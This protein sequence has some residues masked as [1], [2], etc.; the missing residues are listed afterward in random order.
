MAISTVPY[1]L[2]VDD[3]VLVRLDARGILEDAGF[4]CYEAE[5]GDAAKQVLGEMGARIIL[6]F[7]DVQMPGSVDGFALARW[8]DD[9]W[10]EVEIVV[11]SGG[12][13]PSPGDLPDKATFI[14][15]PFDAGVVHSHLAKTLPDGKKPEPLKKAV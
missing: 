6:L 13:K 1:A 3:D 4:R 5:T 14:A 12:V 7:T 8:T 15:K 9:N 10:P 2:V 11:A